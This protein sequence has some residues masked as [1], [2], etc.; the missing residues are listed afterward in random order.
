ME[1]DNKEEKNPKQNHPSKSKNPTK[2]N[3]KKTQT[4]QPKNNKE[5]LS[6]LKLLWRK[7]V[8]FWKYGHLNCVFSC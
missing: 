1:I 2:K 7:L 6:I 4:N 8:E 5:T 3:N